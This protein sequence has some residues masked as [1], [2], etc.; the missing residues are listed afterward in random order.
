[1]LIKIKN[2]VKENT[3]YDSASPTD[4]ISTEGID[5]RPL[6]IRRLIAIEC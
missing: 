2:L 5:F 3:L 1:M 4:K 6:A